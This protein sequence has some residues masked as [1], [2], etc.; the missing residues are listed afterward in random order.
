M[1]PKMMP[2]KSTIHLPEKSS[3]ASLNKKLKMISVRMQEG[4]FSLFVSSA[5]WENK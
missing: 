5:Y 4:K 1:F 3:H 2:L